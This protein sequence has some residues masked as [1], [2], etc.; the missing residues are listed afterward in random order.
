MQRL[1][2]E[3]HML[4][5][6]QGQAI[7][8]RDARRAVRKSVTSLSLVW[9]EVVACVML[10]SWGV[11]QQSLEQVCA[12]ACACTFLCVTES[13]NTFAGIAVCVWMS[14]SMCLISNDGFRAGV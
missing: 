8:N 7:H 1:S 11:C 14:T 5:R 6:K 10:W 12:R 2:K 13:V 9:S 3:A 4:S